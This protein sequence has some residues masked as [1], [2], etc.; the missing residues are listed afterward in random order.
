MLKFQGP[1]R[2]AALCVL[3]SAVLLLVAPVLGGFSRSGFGSVPFGLLFL[4]VFYGL[5]QGWRWLAYLAFFLCMIAAILALSNAWTLNALPSWW[6]VTIAVLF[7][8]GIL[9]LFIALWRSPAR[10]LL[11]DSQS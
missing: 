11:N 5:S 9:T 7:A 8:L 3:A 1:Y 2:L 4:S 6:Y 10:D